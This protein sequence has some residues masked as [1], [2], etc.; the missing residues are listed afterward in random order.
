MSAYVI[1]DVE[2]RDIA[3]CRAFMEG[4]APALHAAGA[5]YL[6]RDA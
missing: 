5:R 3:S 6:A 2:I 4:A 1:F